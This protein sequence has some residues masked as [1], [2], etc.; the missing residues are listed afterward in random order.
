MKG[1]L[2]AVDV[3]LDT[4][5]WTSELRDGAFLSP[6]VGACSGSVDEVCIVVAGAVVATSAEECWGGD[7]GAQLLW[8]GI[9]VLDTVFGDVADDAGRDLDVVDVDDL[10]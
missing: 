8:R 6:V 10:T 3:E 1:V 4:G 7:V 9:P 5:E 2:V